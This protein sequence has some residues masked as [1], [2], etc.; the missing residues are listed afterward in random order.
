ML[1]EQ[2]LRLLRQQGVE[3]ISG[4]E[5]GRQLGVSRT[6]VWKIIAQLRQEG[7]VI[8][9]YPNRGYALLGADDVLSEEELLSRLHTRRVGRRL[10]VLETVR[11]TNE[12]LQGWNEEEL[13]PGFVVLA[14]QQTGGRGKNNT[15]FPSPV[16]K[17]VYMSLYTQPDLPFERVRLLTLAAAMAVCHTLEE[18]GVSPVISY[19]N[20][21]LLEGKKVCG[22]L[23]EVTAEAENLRVENCI[24]GIGVYVNALPED[25]GADE[26][27]I[28]LRMAT[29]RPQDRNAIAARVLEWYETYEDQLLEGQ[30]RP[31][32]EGYRRRLREMNQ[33]V[34]LTDGREMTVTNV[35]VQGRLVGRDA[36]GRAVKA[37]PSQLKKE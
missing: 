25:F 10:V 29:G 28:S 18:Q 12:T 36:R 13:C 15:R 20:D 6:A 8:E 14:G 5:M 4:G 9:S 11:S 26:N 32:L 16:K 33:R 35:D 2:V 17:G 7:Y 3:G 21:I 19:P 22:I 27:R 23:S 24:L 37:A 30:T 1:K 34:R 31:L